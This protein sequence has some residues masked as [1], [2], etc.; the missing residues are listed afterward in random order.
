MIVMN[1][2]KIIQEDNKYY[3]K[4]CMDREKIKEEINNI[5]FSNNLMEQLNE[6]TLVKKD[7]LMIRELMNRINKSL[8]II[9]ENKGCTCELVSMIKDILRGDKND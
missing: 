8:L 6:F 5:L 9:D 7:E 2:E 1:E 4:F 3:Y